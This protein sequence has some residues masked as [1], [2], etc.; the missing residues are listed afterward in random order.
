MDDAD[1]EEEREITSNAIVEVAADG[2]TTGKFVDLQW[3]WPPLPQRGSFDV[4]RTRKSLYFF[5]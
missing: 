3:L 5:S 4:T 1:A 2:T